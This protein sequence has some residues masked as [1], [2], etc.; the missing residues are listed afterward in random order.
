MTDDKS[1]VEHAVE[2]VMYAPIGFVLE[3][4]KLMPTFVERGRQKVQMAKM[5]GQFAVKQGQVEAEKR[6]VNV[7]AHADS[8]LSEFGLRSNGDLTVVGL[9]ESDAGEAVADDTADAVVTPIV[10]AAP[11]TRAVSAEDLAIADYD[12]LAA[13]QVIPRLPGLEAEELA[14]VGRYE[15]ANRHRKTILGKIAQ[16]QGS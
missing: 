16:I 8:V 2:V 11:T 1:P 4:R 5:V 6:L 7:A 9:H 12:S 3:V 15:T 10:P 14:A 13:S